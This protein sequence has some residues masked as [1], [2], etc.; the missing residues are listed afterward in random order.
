MHPVEGGVLLGGS[1]TT[2]VFVPI[3]LPIIEDTVVP[4][5]PCDG[6]LFEVLEW[7]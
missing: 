4:T 1:L 5:P 7:G 6:K 2:R 3:T